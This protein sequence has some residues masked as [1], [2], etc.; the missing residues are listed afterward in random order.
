MA[1]AG[2]ST[3][4]AQPPAPGIEGKGASYDFTGK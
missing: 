1:G 3:E 4:S 2:W